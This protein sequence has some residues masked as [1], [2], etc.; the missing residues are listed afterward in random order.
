M[1]ARSHIANILSREEGTG[2]LSKL[3]DKYR[4][5]NVHLFFLDHK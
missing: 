1:I 4:S 5:K 3:L 2:S